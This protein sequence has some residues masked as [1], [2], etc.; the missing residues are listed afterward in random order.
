MRLIFGSTNSF[1]PEYPIIIKS[2]PISEHR[3]STPFDF[4]TLSQQPVHLV[5]PAAVQSHYAAIIVVAHDDPE[6]A[7]APA[8]RHFLQMI[9]VSVFWETLASPSCLAPD[10]SAIGR[11][12]DQQKAILDCLAKGTATVKQLTGWGWSAEPL[13][14]MSS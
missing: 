7:L 2:T 3:N 8:T 14:L 5:F 10:Y 11:F 6:Y 4:L 12:S 9:A 13:T 1:V